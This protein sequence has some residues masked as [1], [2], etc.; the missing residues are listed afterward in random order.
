LNILI[1]A[2][3]AHS[4]IGQWQASVQVKLSF[5][6]KGKD[7]LASARSSG[8]CPAAALASAVS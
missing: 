4:D 2:A 5:P 3:A 1:A 8:M 7:Q 6:E